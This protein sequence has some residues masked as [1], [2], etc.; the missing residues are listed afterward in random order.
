[1][2]KRAVLYA[3]VSGDDRQN[4]TSSIEGQLELCREYASNLGYEI[5]AELA[6][7]AR[8]ASGASWDLP[9]LNEAFELAMASKFD[10]LVTR[11]LDRLARDLAKQLVAENEFAR[12][13]VEVEYVIGD[14]QDNPEG[15]LSKHIRAVIAQYERVK[16]KERMVR[17]RRRKAKSGYVV[18]HGNVLYGYKA[19]KDEH[20]TKLEIDEAKA[21]IVRM[22][23]DWYTVEGLGTPTIA[24]KLNK[25]GILP[26]SAA[27]KTKTPRATNWNQAQVYR[28]IKNETYAGTWRYGKRNRYGK[29]PK[30]HHITVEVPAIISREV[31]ELAQKKRDRNK[32]HAK[33]NAKNDYLLARRCYCGECQAS[34]AALTKHY[35]NGTNYPYYRCPVPHSQGTHFMNKKCST[36][37][38]FRADYWDEAIWNE[39]RYFLS[40]P[41][42][43]IKGIK[44]YKEEQESKNAPLWR[45]IG[46]LDDL[47]GQKKTE[48]DRLLDLYLSGEFAKDVL[49]DRKQ[50]LEQ[51]IE[52]LEE[53]KESLLA[54]LRQTITNEQLDE[55]EIFAQHVAEGFDEA[56]EDFECRRKILDFLNLKT[57]FSYEDEIEVAQ[58][59][60]E[61]GLDEQIAFDK[62]SK[63]FYNPSHQH[64]LE[65]S[66]N[67]RGEG[68][69]NYMP[70]Y[71]H[72]MD[73]RQS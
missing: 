70:S 14:Y 18:L 41:K 67:S 62:E 64:E 56:N 27:K 36:T 46:I 37:K 17:G 65:S 59:Y 1:M 34:M 55:L 39:V 40:N 66:A 26:P 42:K 7:D 49:M 60:C 6:E 12:F 10:V 5:V 73:C 28:I 63:T 25:L 19:V 31:F 3:R 69:G 52:S 38:H 72:S 51:T 33:Y 20:G 48:L 53:E 32:N 45:R 16:I 44:Q 61:F 43:L 54:N 11:E 4:S 71:K 2:T 58:I 23:F 57:S 68:A 13:G 15:E 8:G 30:E 9:K 47:L 35:P 22:I 29:N 21:E 50:R 24:R